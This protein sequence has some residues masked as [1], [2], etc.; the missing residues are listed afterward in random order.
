[1]NLGKPSLITSVSATLAGTSVNDIAQLIAF[2][3]A[4]ISGLMAI[5]HYW[6]GT[7]LTRLQ[8]QTIEEHHNESEATD[9]H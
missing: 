2:V 1:M 5:R 7:K 3:V 9:N 4:I 8:I 6:I